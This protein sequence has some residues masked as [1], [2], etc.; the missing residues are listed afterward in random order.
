VAVALE[1]A[2]YTMVPA[3]IAVMAAGRLLLHRAYRA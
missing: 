3:G 2:S 1:V